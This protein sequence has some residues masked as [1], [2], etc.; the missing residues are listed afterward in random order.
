MPIVIPLTHVL[1]PAQTGNVWLPNTF[2]HCLVTKHGDVDVCDQTVKTCLIELRWNST[3]KDL[4]VI[5]A[6]CSCILCP[7]YECPVLASSHTLYLFYLLSGTPLKIHPTDNHFVP[8][9]RSKD[10]SPLRSIT[11]PFL[12][13][14]FV[15]SVSISPISTT[16]TKATYVNNTKTKERFEVV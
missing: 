12:C 14:V 9:D 5:A 8:T 4:W 10:P 7:Q 3:S 15:S 6:Q 2:K 13:I 1:R 16:S 11:L